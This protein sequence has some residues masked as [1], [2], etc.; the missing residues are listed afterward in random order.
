MGPTLRSLIHLQ[1]IEKQLRERRAAMRRTEQVVKQREHNL[2]QLRA[3]LSAKEEEVKLTR[4]QSSKLELDLRSE[5]DEIT[6]LRVALNTAKT[7]KDYSAILTRINTDKADKSKLEDQILTLMTQADGDQLSCRELGEEIERDGEQLD[8]VRKE[9]AGKQIQ[10]QAQIDQL[11][12]QHHQA[13]EQ[14]PENER[15]VFCRL[16]ERFD[17]EVMVE[18]VKA[19]L[20]KTEHNCGG[21]YMTIPLELVNSLMTRDE[22]IL[23]PSCGRILVLD[24]NPTGQTT[25]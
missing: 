7:N 8:E 21:C 22:L 12:R 18:V 9:Y 16:V 2:S 5:E 10:I 25:V 24:L 13:A 6:K 14:V 19:R 3:T 1:A 23:C 4:L 20:R 15:Q 17:G 11:A